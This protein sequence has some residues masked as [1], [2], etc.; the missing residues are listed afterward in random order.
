MIE[1][2]YLD[3]EVLDVDEKTKQVK[4][5]IAS[6]AEVDRD[7][8]IF[9]DSA[10]NRTIKNMGPQ[11]A[12]EMWHLLDH[13]GSNPRNPSIREAAL[14]KP[15]EVYMEGQKMVFISP[16]RD[17]FNWREI[18]W[19]L[20]TNKDITQHSCGFITIKSHNENINGKSVRVI[21]EA[22]VLEGSAV[23]WG[24]N[25]NTPTMEVI[26]KSFL[27][28]REVKENIGDRFT[29]LYKSIKSG[30]YD[31]ENV[32]LLRLEFKYLEDYILE[33]ESKQSTA[34]AEEKAT[35]PQPE[36]T[37]KVLIAI[38]QFNNRFATN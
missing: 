14:S 22:A 28:K 30:E 19:P 34:P 9:D 29:R 31:E 18:A 27:Q 38:Q 12:N 21:E 2:K 4:I 3:T 17:T 36:E 15:K 1:H 6:T 26:I 16:Y 35:H 11:G 24:A 25:P 7:S 32:S 10:F 37:S 33:L 13:G 5:A 20:Y 23:L 8:D